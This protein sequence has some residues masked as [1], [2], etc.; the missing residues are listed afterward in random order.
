[1]EREAEQVTRMPNCIITQTSKTD[2]GM[3]SI[4]YT[5]IKKT[6]KK[7]SLHTFLHILT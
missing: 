7:K 4:K 5:N 6:K 3:L 2:T 1:M